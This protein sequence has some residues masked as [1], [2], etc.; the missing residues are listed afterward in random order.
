M[1][2]QHQFGVS[3][4]RYEGPIVARG[5]VIRFRLVPFLGFD[6]APRLIDL[7]VLNRHVLYPVLKEPFQLF[8]YASNRVRMVPWCAPVKRSTAL[9]L[10]PSTSIPRICAAFSGLMYIPPKRFWRPSPNVRLHLVH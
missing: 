4:N 2:C 9:T 7:H 5:G 8:A 6:E 3:L 1:P 10:I